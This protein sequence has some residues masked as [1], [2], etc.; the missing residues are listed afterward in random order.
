MTH[1]YRCQES[2]HFWILDKV[3][4]R[5]VERHWALQSLIL[6][7]GKK[8]Q[9]RNEKVSVWIGCLGAFRSARKTVV[10]K[11]FV[12]TPFLDLFPGLCERG[13]SDLYLVV[14]GDIF[15]LSSICDSWFLSVGRERAE[16]RS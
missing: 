15:R 9:K 13:K 12:L 7:E 2:F 10:A 5:T 4:L 11:V 16:R 3:A 8:V 6:M 1:A 14:G